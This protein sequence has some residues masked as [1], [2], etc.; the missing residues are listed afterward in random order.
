[1]S[2][3]GDIN[4]ANK[5]EYNKGRLYRPHSFTISAEQLSKLQTKA[6]QVGMNTSE[7]LRKMINN[8]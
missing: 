5:R 8:L 4:M 6:E 7:Y 1:M 3:R 2:R